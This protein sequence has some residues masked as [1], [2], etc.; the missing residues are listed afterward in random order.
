MQELRAQKQAEID[1][2]KPATKRLY[3]V[4][5]Q[6]ETVMKNAQSD[7]YDAY[8][9]IEKLEREIATIDQL[10]QAPQEVTT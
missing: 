3:E 1:R 2:L 10:L 9:P 7:W 6:A 4:F 5:K 8:L